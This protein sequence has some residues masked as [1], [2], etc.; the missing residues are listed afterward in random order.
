[1][2]ESVELRNRIA[3]LAEADKMIRKLDR[4]SAALTK[5]LR[6]SKKINAELRAAEMPVMLADVAKFIECLLPYLDARPDLKD[7][8]QQFLASPIVR[9]LLQVEE[10]VS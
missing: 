7:Q 8:A 2:K 6:A 5:Q 10:E 3:Q 9:N 1:M 4:I